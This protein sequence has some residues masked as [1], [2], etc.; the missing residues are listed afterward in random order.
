MHWAEHDRVWHQVATWSYREVFRFSSLSLCFPLL[1]HTCPSSTLASPFGKNENKTTRAE[2]VYTTGHGDAWHQVAPRSFIP[3]DI[4]ILKSR[5]DPLLPSPTIPSPPPHPSLRRRASL[6]SM[7]IPGSSLHKSRVVW[8][9][10]GAG[11]TQFFSGCGRREQC[12]AWSPAPERKVFGVL[13]WGPGGRDGRSF[14]GIFIGSVSS[15]VLWWRSLT[16]RVAVTVSELNNIV[17]VCADTYT[18]LSVWASLLH[19][20]FWGRETK[21]WLKRVYML[22]YT[23]IMFKWSEDQ[24]HWHGDRFAILSQVWKK[25]YR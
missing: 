13:L 24:C 20:R 2:K 21:L 17:L 23:R 7:L 19:C 14:S 22:V 10:D 3:V 18:R 12:S 6:F 15:V 11:C 25:Y 5:S 4:L 8:S 9:P 16:N 1:W